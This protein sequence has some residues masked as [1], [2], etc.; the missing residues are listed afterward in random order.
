MSQYVRFTSASLL[1][2]LV[3]C[4][5]SPAHDPR[6]LP[7]VIYAGADPNAK[8]AVGR[9][10]LMFASSYGYV[11]IVTM[12]LAK[13]ADVNRV[14]DDKTGWSALMAVAHNGHAAVVSLLLKSGANQSIV[15]VKGKTA[16][17]LAEMRGQT[18]AIR[19][20]REH[21]AQLPPL[22]Q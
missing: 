21:G 12:L 18:E 13:G 7:Q 8:N 17:G 15:D 10:P 5:S 19:A 20:L 9:T 14:P 1:F 11:P 3:S 6:S 22:T 4:A 2:L 16:L